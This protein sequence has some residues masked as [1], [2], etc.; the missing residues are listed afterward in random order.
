MVHIPPTPLG[1]QMAEAHVTGPDMSQKLENVI[2]FLLRPHSL[3]SHNNLFGFFS[4]ASQI[5]SCFIRI[6]Y[7]SQKPISKCLRQYRECL[8]HKKSW[9]SVALGQL[10]EWLYRIIKQSGSFC[11]SALLSSGVGL[12]LRCYSSLHDYEAAEVPDVTFRH[13]MSG[14]WRGTIAFCGSIF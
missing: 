2:S 5:P 11:P 1:S 9:G 4:R 10:I 14:G 13:D 8:F 6:L 3:L 12:L 7:K